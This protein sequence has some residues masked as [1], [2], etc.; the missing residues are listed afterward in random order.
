MITI[1][2]LDILNDFLSIFD[3]EAL[4]KYGGLFLVFLIVYGTTGLFFCFF[5]PT[6]AFLFATGL[7]AAAGTLNYNIFTI[8]SLLTLASV[9]GNITGYWFGRKTGPLLYKREDSRFFKKK[10][11]ATA[12]SFYKKHGWLA[13]TLGLYLPIIRTFAPI[14]AGMV[15]LNFRRFM[16]LTVAGSVVWIL[17]FVL[18]GYAIGRIPALKPW[19]NYIVL[20]FI[21]I[22]TVPLIIW[23]VKELR[24]LK[25]ENKVKK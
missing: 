22:V 2:I 3:V 10:H 14:V 16:L 8:C 23:V 21:L 19:L 5:I 12:E 6:G 17:S 9:L 20:V 4:I 18:V 7:F 24:K 25:K 1:S 15:K 11:L 13:L